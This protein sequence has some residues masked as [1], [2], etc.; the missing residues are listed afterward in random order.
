MI[1][2]KV[3]PYS[4]TMV[5]EYNA[6]VVD[7]TARSRVM[8]GSY[9]APIMDDKPFNSVDAN[10]T[11]TQPLVL[12]DVTSFVFIECYDQFT[13]EVTQGGQTITQV[14]NGVFLYTGA[15]EQ[16]RILP[17]PA[18]TTVRIKYVYA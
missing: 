10:A 3:L 7:S 8:K 17:K 5:L 4:R 9:A 2:R 11:D 16:I 18:A 13:L 6:Q 15:V 14:C 12:T 1:N